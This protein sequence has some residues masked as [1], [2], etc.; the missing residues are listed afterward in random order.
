MA[1]RPWLLTAEGFRPALNL[2]VHNSFNMVYDTRF[3]MT[4]RL[5]TLSEACFKKK[6][7]IK[8]RF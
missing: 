5:R 8:A 4:D 3:N 6:R 1:D 7:L 2:I